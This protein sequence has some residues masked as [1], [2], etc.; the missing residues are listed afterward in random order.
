MM[1]ARRVMQAPEK[2]VR[3]RLQRARFK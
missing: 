2:A 3:P 1:A